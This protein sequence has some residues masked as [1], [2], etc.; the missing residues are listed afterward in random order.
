MSLNAKAFDSVS[1]GNQSQIACLLRTHQR[2]LNRRA[3][4]VN[5]KKAALKFR[6]HETLIK[7]MENR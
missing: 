2:Q 5:G 3:H 6:I 4:F 7:Q 1:A